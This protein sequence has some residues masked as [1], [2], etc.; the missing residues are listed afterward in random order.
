M[1]TRFAAMLLTLAALATPCLAQ[2]EP[3]F[4]YGGKA[5]AADDLSIR[6]Q[7]LYGSVLAEHYQSMRTLVDEMVFDV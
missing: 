3:L 7:Q 6:M 2:D 1:S 4:E 5:Y